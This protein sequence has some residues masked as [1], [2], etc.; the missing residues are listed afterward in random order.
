MPCK[1]AIAQRACESLSLAVALPLHGLAV[2][3]GERAHQRR[4]VDDEGRVD[5]VDLQ[6]LANELVPGNQARGS[7]PFSS[8]SLS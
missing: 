7:K 5:A 8:M 4:M 2:R 3:L 6:E 1:T